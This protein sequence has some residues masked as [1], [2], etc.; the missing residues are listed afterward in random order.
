MRSC[1][2]F[3]LVLPSSVTVCM[4]ALVRVLLYGLYVYSYGVLLSI[5]TVF[6]MMHPK[7][8][9]VS[10][11]HW[12]HCDDEIGVQQWWTYCSVLNISSRARSG[13]FFLLCFWLHFVWLTVLRVME[14]KKKAQG[15]FLINYANTIKQDI[16][17]LFFCPVWY[18][19][20]DSNCFCHLHIDLILSSRVLIKETWQLYPGPTS[21]GYHPRET[22]PPLDCRWN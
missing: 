14:G 3:V 10:L 12:V 5:A 15:M 8:V 17:G 13:F 16:P 11:S 22:Q 7:A 18:S 1:C 4:P 21:T 2:F 9:I 19:I 6:V 20:A